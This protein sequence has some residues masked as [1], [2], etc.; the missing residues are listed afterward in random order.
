MSSTLIAN[1]GLYHPTDRFIKAPNYVNSCTMG[2]TGVILTLPAGANYVRLSAN[3]DFFVCWGSSGVSTGTHTT[4]LGSEIVPYGTEIFR[5]MTTAGTT[6][7]SVS[8][9]A[10]SFLS[11][12]WWT[13]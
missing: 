7:V 2:S 4:G 6:M 12:S 9:T 3:A 11:Q 13:V 5:Q 10:V 1:T 8:S